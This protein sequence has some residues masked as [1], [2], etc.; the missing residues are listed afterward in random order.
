[1]AARQLKPDRPKPVIQ[2][3]VNKNET[4]NKQSETTTNE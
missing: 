4:P 3:P 1:V 2:T